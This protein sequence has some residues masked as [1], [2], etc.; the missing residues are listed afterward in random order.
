MNEPI[1][2]SFTDYQAIESGKNPTAMEEI[3]NK[4]A[5]EGQIYIVKKDGTDYKVALTEKGVGLVPM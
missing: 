1:I 2:L 3:M 5:D 4:M